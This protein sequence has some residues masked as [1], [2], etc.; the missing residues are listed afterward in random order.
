MYKVVAEMLKYESTYFHE[1][2]E[3]F[4]KNRIQSSLDQNKKLHWL[5]RAKNLNIF[6]IMEITSKFTCKL[7]R[8]PLFDNLN[9]AEH[10]TADGQK[11]FSYQK[12]GYYHNC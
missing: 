11:S 5:A 10:E 2:K 3:S 12:R 1:K 6:I 7:C 4:W 9:L 8:T